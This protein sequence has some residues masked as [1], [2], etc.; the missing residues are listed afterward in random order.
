MARKLKVPGRKTMRLPYRMDGTGGKQDAMQDHG[1]WWALKDANDARAMAWNCYDLL[2]AT[3]TTRNARDALHT[4]L[5]EGEP[6]LWLGSLVPGS[7]LLYQASSTMDGYTK[8]RANLI[9]RCVDTGV[10]MIAKNIIEIRCVTDGGAWGLQ[11]KARQ[12]TKFINGSLREMDFH[13]AQQRG[14]VDGMLTRTGGMIKPWIDWENQ[15]IVCGRIHPSNFVWNEGEGQRLRTLYENTPWSRSELVARFPKMKDEILDAPQS[16]RPVNQA[17]RRL[18]ENETLADMVDVLEA[19]HLGTGDKNPGRKMVLLK[20]CILDD[21]DE[22]TL[23]NFGYARFCWDDADKGWQCK[24]ASDTLIGYHYQI[25]RLMRK[26]DRGQSLA[27]VPRVWIEQGSE[28]SEDEL[29]NEMGG[30]GHYRGTAPQIATASAFPPEVYHYL[31]WLFEQGMADIGFNQMQSQGLKPPGIDAAVAIREYNDTGTARQIPKG[32]RLERQAEDMGELIM[33]LGS[34]LAEKDSSFSINALGAGSYDH[35]KWSEVEGDSRDIRV[36]SNP[37]SALPSTTSGKIQ[38]VTDLIKGGLLPPEE[39]QGGL[40]LK[41]LNF[42]D[43]EK[44]ITME[45]ANRELAEMQVDLA[46][47]EGKYLAPEPYQSSGGLKLL[48]TLACRQ[49]FVALGLTG[50]PE[51]NMDLLQR[52]MN[53]ADQLDQR[54][55]GA[56]SIGQPVAAPPPPAGPTLEQSPMAP[57]IAPIPAPPGGVPMPAP[58]MQAPGGQ[59]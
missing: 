12:R 47:Y 55:S 22:W 11:K 37:V 52:L 43:L 36:H 25:G 31:D 50:V 29:T 53:E 48:K 17:Y 21:D 23:Q 26:I 35:V 18:Q 49:Y 32:Q 2:Y 16:A 33:Y 58:P 10:S 20:N 15:R 13:T 19:T 5:Y 38:T 54:L 41:L 45:T 14:V 46:L 6:P 34:K 8:A 42:P 40:A 28:V 9:R 4:G 39:V 24:P 56:V 30:V 57:P 44:V 27:L 7:P 3:H 59:Q 51:R 1:R